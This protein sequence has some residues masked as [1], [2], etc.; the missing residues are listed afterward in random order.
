MSQSRHDDLGLG[1]MLLP[2]ALLFIVLI[3][4]ALFL[5]AHDTPDLLSAHQPTA[6]QQ[7]IAS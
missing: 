7:T 2:A 5:T 4:G 3:V 1:L 6:A